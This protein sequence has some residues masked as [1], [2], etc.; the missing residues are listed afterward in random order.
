MKFLITTL[1]LA[2]S[3]PVHANERIG[4]HRNYDAYERIGYRRNHEAYESQKGYAY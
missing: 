4:Y 2:A 3:F 1:I